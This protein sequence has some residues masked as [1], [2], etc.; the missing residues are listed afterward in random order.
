MARLPR[1]AVCVR[2]AGLLFVIAILGAVTGWF[3]DGAVGLM[4]IVGPALGGVVFTVAAHRLSGRG[5]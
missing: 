1:S 4:A 2:L 5:G 3:S